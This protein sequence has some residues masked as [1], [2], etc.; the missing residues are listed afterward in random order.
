VLPELMQTG[1]KKKKL[2]EDGPSGPKHVGANIRHFNVNF[3]ILY[4]Q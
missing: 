3:N 1:L 4:V 2:P